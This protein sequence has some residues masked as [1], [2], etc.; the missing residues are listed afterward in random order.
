MFRGVYDILLD[1]K[2]DERLQIL[3]DIVVEDA[4]WKVVISREGKIEIDA[5]TVENLHALRLIT[6]TAVRHASY[7][8]HFTLSSGTETD[9]SSGLPIS[10]T[11][12]SEIGV[13]SHMIDI[14]KCKGTIRSLLQTSTEALPFLVRS[15]DLL[16]RY[17]EVSALIALTALEIQLNEAVKDEDLLVAQKLAV[18]RYLDILHAEQIGALKNLFTLRNRLAH[19]LWSGEKMRNALGSVCGGSPDDWVIASVGRMKKSASQK[20]VEKVIGALSFLSTA[21]P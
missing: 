19:G 4:S 1:G 13:S 18:L 7:W 17:A 10:M 2:K 21:K 11:L 3:C 6:Q 12:Y 14:Q 20:V 5:D 8:M 16:D 9:L 15:T